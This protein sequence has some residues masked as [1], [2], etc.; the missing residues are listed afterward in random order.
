MKKEEMEEGIISKENREAQ[1]NGV[2]SRW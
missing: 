2:T 1:D